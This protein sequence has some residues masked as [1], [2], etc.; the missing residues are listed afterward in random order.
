MALLITDTLSGNSQGV[1]LC[2]SSQQ[3]LASICC[4]RPGASDAFIQS[5]AL[6]LC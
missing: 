4:I 5:D 3:M 2:H 6:W 1:A